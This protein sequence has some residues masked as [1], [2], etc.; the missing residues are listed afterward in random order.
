MRLGYALVQDGAASA[1]DQVLQ[2]VA[3]HA[4]LFEGHQC[5]AVLP[6]YA[7]IRSATVLTLLHRK[8]FCHSDFLHSCFLQTHNS[9][10]NDRKLMKEE[11]NTKILR[12]QQC[13]L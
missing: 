8:L 9:G 1:A 5:L 3:E 12:K 13:G 6:A 4:V 10:N 7:D 11:P 2:A